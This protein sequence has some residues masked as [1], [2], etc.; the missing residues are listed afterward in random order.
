MSDSFTFALRI[1]A[2][3]RRSS[4]LLSLAAA[5]ILFASNAHAQFGAPAAGTQVKDASALHPPVGARVAIV[6]FSDFECPA[7]AHANPTLMAAAATYKIPWVRH[8]FLIPGHIWSTQAAVNARWFDLNK[9]KAVGEEYRNQ[10]FAN[11]PS[12]YS[13]DALSQFTQKFAQSHGVSLPFSL[14]PQG[15]LLAEVQADNEMGKRTGILHTP[16]VFIVTANGKGAPFREVQ[17]IDQDLYLAI[18]QALA[19][20]VPVKPAP[21]PPTKK[22]VTK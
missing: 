12:I 9:S 2:F 8:D 15:K 20:T 16:T 1:S 22:P 17:N 19:D 3:T 11:Q 18:D 4:L 10:L 14:D 6:E 21:K 7:C 5:V 13:L